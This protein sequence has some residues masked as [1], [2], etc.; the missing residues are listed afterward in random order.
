MKSSKPLRCCLHESLHSATVKVERKAGHKKNTAR[1]HPGVTNS[2]LKI[3]FAER[4]LLVNR[5]PA[6]VD[7]S[8]YFLQPVQNTA[9]AEGP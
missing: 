1:G 7:F 6:G 3:G 9:R 4:S 8:L 2:L 5:R